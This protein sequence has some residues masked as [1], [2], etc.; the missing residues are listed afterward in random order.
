MLSFLKSEFFLSFAMN[1]Q[2]MHS[3][4]RV[5]STGSFATA[6]KSVNLTASAVS[7]Q[8]KQL[9]EYT[10]KVLFDRSG[11]RVVPTPEALQLAP[12]I[13]QAMEI[14]DGIRDARERGVEGV[15][16]LGVIASVEKAAMPRALRI[17]RAE[18]PALAI[19][20]SLDVSGGLIESI[21]AG[22]IDVA[23]LIRPERGGSSRLAWTNLVRER[24]VLAVPAALPARPAQELLRKLPWIR[25]DVNLT[26]G[27]IAA[28][29]VQ[30]RAPGTKASFDLISIDA[31]LAMVAEGLGVSVVPC[32]AGLVPPTVRI[33]ELGPAAPSRQ[34]ALLTRRAD[35][36]DRRVVALSSAFV[37]AYG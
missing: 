8:M 12:A 27:R 7:L 19:Q 25:Y 2:S 36:E 22:R 23:A 37:A 11:R 5:L 10:G 32:P 33:V 4:L 29:W 14:L 28:S 9:E 24:L 21:K 26:G 1:I 35:A 6:A 20:L 18:H 16:R 31:I 30:Q 15:I 13:A 34:V 17:L 3:F